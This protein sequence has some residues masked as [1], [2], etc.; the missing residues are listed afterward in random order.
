MNKY[1]HLFVDLDD[2]LF[3]SSSLYADAIK[4]SYE[5]L[6]SFYPEV[7]LKKFKTNFL[8]IRKDLKEKYKHQALSHNR[9]ILFSHLLEKL[10]IPFNAELIRELYEAY[11]FTV[12]VYIQPFPGVKEVLKKVKE[13]N[14][15]I[16][17]VSDG[18]LLSRLEKL[19]SLKLSE[20]IDHLVAAE[21]VIYTK[22]ERPIFELA[23]EKSKANKEEVLM[24][25]DSFSADITGGEMFGID[26]CWFNPNKRRK[27]IN[28]NIKP[29][30]VI[31][32]FTELLNILQIK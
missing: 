24:V 32:E 13:N 28:P 17:A 1:K 3:D 31:H 8:I 21:E 15:K 16:T 20:Y 19:E 2:T 5:R 30:Y 7:T 10:N 6:H 27:P 12:N 25:G 14:I 26:T 23:I 18:S 22:P 11:W 4:M 29:D 9:A